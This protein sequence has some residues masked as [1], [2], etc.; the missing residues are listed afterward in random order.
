MNRRQDLESGTQFFSVSPIRNQVETE[1][2]W[3]A[4]LRSTFYARGY[5]WWS[6]YRNQNVFL[7]GG[8]LQERR[9]VDNGKTAEVG[10][11]YRLTEN[12]RL[13]AE[14]GL[15]NNN[16]NITRYTYTSN[17]YTVSLQYVF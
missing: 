14:Y 4:T 17:R 9:R 10:L 1:L 15:R 8:A 13:T 7:Q 12:V 11:I 2:R 5:Y 16:S 3:N 6:I